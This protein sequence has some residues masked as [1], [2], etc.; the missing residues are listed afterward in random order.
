[1]WGPGLGVKDLVFGCSRFRGYTTPRMENQKYKTWKRVQMEV[2]QDGRP[3]G[4]LGM[5]Q[6]DCN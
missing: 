3:L 5:C 1:M 6:R 4:T 2:S